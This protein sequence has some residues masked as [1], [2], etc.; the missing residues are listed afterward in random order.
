MIEKMQ[1]DEG[2]GQLRTLL[3][4]L[5][6]PPRYFIR[7][8]GCQQNVSD[9]ERI[10]GMLTQCGYMPAASLPEADLVVFNTCAV[11]A[12]AE[13]RVFGN[14]GELKR[15]KEEK[16]DLVIALGGCM[17]QQRHIADKLRRSYPFV[18]IIFNTNELQ[19]LPGTIARHM[20]TRRPVVAIE[21]EDYAIQEGL[22]V[23]REGQYRAFIPIMYGCDNFCTYC[24][25]PLVRGRERSRR[26]ADVLAEFRQ[27]VA[28]GYKDIMLLGQNVNSYG[29]G[30]RE[31]IDFA[32][33]LELLCRTEGEYTLRF[34]TSHP[35]DAG[36]R[37]FDTMARNPKISRHVHLPVQSG[38]DRV[39]AA[40]NRKYTK[41]TY[42]ALIRYARSVMPDVSFSSDII[43]GFPG[44][45][46]EDFEQTLELVREAGYRSL[47]TFIYSRREGTPAA[48]LPDDTPHKAKTQR[49]A[50]LIA[51]QDTIT[52]ARDDELEGKTCRVLVTDKLPDGR[53]EGRL[54]DNTVVTLEG[55]GAVNAFARCVV[56]SARKKRLYGKVIEQHE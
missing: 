1:F 17:V 5:A 39:L 29:K 38:S 37:L 7:T 40:M 36:R 55:G 18:D 11:R 22:P 45:T 35:K 44:E 52:K 56:T 12:H 13:D 14:V 47:F 41:D 8:F 10:A 32:G 26:S 54:D 53:F 21:C 20:E 4:G 25:V 15:L 46:E 27:A 16:E 50:R 31:D 19:R 49:M 48:E 2:A 34:M 33:L 24:V 23:R 3:S 51:L 9:S 30:L 42:M 28:D 43:V 6:R